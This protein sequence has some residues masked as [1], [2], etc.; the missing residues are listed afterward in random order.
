MVL[1]KNAP[2]KAPVCANAL[3]CFSVDLSDGLY[4]PKNQQATPLFVPPTAVIVKSFL[5]G[6]KAAKGKEIHIQ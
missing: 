3:P 2:G 4:N 5:G 6:E 1:V